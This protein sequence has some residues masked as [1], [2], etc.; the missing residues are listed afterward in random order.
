MS[1]R[2]IMHEIEAIMK[3]VE[4]ELLLQAATAYLSIGN[5]HCSNCANW[6]HNGLI[7]IEGV[8]KVAV[9]FPQ[10][11]AAVSYDA[12]RIAVQDLLNA[13]ARMGQS[14]C[15]FYWAEHIGQLCDLDR[16]AL[17]RKASLS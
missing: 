15:T 4:E 2:M 11:I 12:S 6:V 14:N 10:S 7:E 3:P 16:L 13:V 1:N 8:F 9:F 5:M 17:R